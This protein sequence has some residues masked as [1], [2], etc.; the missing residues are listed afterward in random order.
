LC[1]AAREAK[2]GRAVLLWRDDLR[3]RRRPPFNTGPTALF[4]AYY[5]SAELACFDQLGWPAPENVLDLYAEF[6]LVTAGGEAPCGHGLLGALAY[7]GLP[8]GVD[9]MTKASFQALA[10]R[11]GPYSAAL[12]QAMLHYCLSD[13]DAVARLLRAMAPAVLRPASLGPAGWPKALGQALLRGE[14]MKAITAMEGRGVPIDTKALAALV[15]SWGGVEAGLITRVDD[16][17]GVYPDGHFSHAAFTA[18]LAR[19]RISWPLTPTGLLRLDKDTRKDM[20]VVYPDLA[21]LHELMSTL[22]QMREWELPVGADGRNRCLLSPFGTKTGR[23]APSTNAYIFNLASWLRG[24]IRP[25]RGTALIYADYEQQEFGIAAALSGDLAMARAY[26][27]GDPYLSFAIQAGAAPEGATKKSHGPVREQFKVCAL[28][29]QYSMGAT[30]LADRLR[31][32]YGRGRELIETHKKTFPGYWR[33]SADCVCFARIFNHLTATFGWRVNVSS[34]ARSTSLRNFLLQ[35]NGSEMLRLACVLCRERG[36]PLCAPVHDALLVEAPA[37]DVEAV[38]A[39]LVGAMTDASALVLPGR[40]LRVETK[41]IRHPHRY[42][43]PRGARMWGTVWGL[44]ENKGKVGRQRPTGKHA[45]G[46][47][48][49]HRL[50]HS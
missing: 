16:A 45:G 23:N 49:P 1:L 11:G 13:A 39:A 4:V 6:R 37:R 18:Y 27:S 26:D 41:V 31:A 8:G 22:K 10:Q 38:K 2:S 36:V 21:P 20:V 33:W 5:A 17:Y 29:I 3:R 9:E 7:H 47:F 14:Y 35:A 48:V 15:D 19:R 30:S 43:D 28:A 34:G 32:S 25:R 50:G 24:L 12:R 46:T 42:A 40:P 44:I